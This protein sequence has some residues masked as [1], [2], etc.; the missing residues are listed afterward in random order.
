MRR[1]VIAAAVTVG[2]LAGAIASPAISSAQPTTPNTIVT[3]AV[4]G[5]NIAIAAESGAQLA[6]ESLTNVATG[7][8]GNVTVTD[9]RRIIGGWTASAVSTSFRTGTPPANGTEIAADQ[10]RYSGGLAVAVSGLPL[11]L[12]GTL[13]NPTP[14]LE[15]TKPVQSATVIGRNA[16][17]WNPT[18]TV[19]LPANRT[20]GTY[21]GT[22]THSVA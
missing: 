19:T 9:D 5:G 11:A 17:R 13:T 2:A 3:F 14:T 6:E 20:A 22:I 1:S 8:L 7:N 21:T 12:P 16:A 15:A 10:V 4:A 18:L